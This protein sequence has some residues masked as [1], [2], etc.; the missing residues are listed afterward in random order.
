[1]CS[2]LVYRVQ[3]DVVIAPFTLSDGQHPKCRSDGET[4]QSYGSVGVREGCAAW[5]LDQE[6]QEHLSSAEI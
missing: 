5:T 3:V 2:C 6:H 4:L 1:M